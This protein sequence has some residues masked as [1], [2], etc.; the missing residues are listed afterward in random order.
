M[1]IATMLLILGV[2]LLV[3]CVIFL[4]RNFLSKYNMSRR[5]F[6]TALILFLIIVAFLCSFAVIIGAMGLQDTILD[7]NS[8]PNI[9]KD[10][11][12]LL[13]KSIPTGI[14]QLIQGLIIGYSLLAVDFIIIKRIQKK[15]Q[16]EVDN[17]A[18]KRWSSF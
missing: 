3:L 15:K 1:L 9:P 7:L 18:N 16:I 8:S 12:D 5:G 10:Q 4:F 17:Y 13:K 14:R 6:L 11:L 2:L